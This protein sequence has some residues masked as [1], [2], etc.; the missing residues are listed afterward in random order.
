[1][2]FNVIM[3]KVYIWLIVVIL[4]IIILGIFF[5]KK[6]SLSPDSGGAGCSVSGVL[7]ENTMTKAQATAFCGAAAGQCKSGR[8]NAFN[9]NSINTGRRQTAS[10]HCQC[11]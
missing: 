4:L 7:Y 1:M 11:A 5:Y 8:C 3:K 9:Y 6:V 2:I 10:F